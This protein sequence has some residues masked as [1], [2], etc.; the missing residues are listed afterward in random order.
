MGFFQSYLALPRRT[1]VLIGVGGMCIALAGSY[2]TN[3]LEEDS[4]KQEARLRDLKQH[5]NSA[6]DHNKT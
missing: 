1:R 4:F 2:L 3:V 5:D 6:S